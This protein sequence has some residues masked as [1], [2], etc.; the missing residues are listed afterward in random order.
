MEVQMD[1]GRKYR[2][3]DIADM[4]ADQLRQKFFTLDMKDGKLVH[5]LDGL[6]VAYE[7]SR[8]DCP[9]NY[10]FFIQLSQGDD[11]IAEFAREQLRD[12]A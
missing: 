2:L 8:R 4:G 12:A 1:E 6:F 7:V 3:G 10:N 11:I 9:V 5:W